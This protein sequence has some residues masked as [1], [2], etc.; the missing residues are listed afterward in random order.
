VTNLSRSLRDDYNP[1]WS[2]DGQYVAFFHRSQQ[3]T[4]QPNQLRIAEVGAGRIRAVS[5]QEGAIYNVRWSPDSQRLWFRMDSAYY[6]YDRA[7][8]AVRELYRISASN[9]YFDSFSESPD[10]RWAL[11]VTTRYEPDTSNTHTNVLLL[12]TASGTTEIVPFS[13]FRLWQVIWSRD[14][15]RVA[16]TNNT[17]YAFVYE[18]ASRRLRHVYVPPPGYTQLWDWS[19]DNRLVWTVARQ[20]GYETHTTFYIGDGHDSPIQELVTIHPPVELVRASPTENLI[21]FQ[22]YAGIYGIDAAR[23]GVF[24]QYVQG[25]GKIGGITWSPDGR[26]LASQIHGIPGRNTHVMAVSD[27]HTGERYLYDE[28]TWVQRD[29]RWSQTGSQLAFTSG[30]R[31]NMELVTLTMPE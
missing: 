21:A 7:S 16:V 22:T 5:R 8:R 29:P 12:D 2:P 20:V 1:I 6:V 30:W 28:D 31:G 15:S 9:T 13:G 25:I 4:S 14:S 26:Y 19:F 17:T 18:I 10:G 23:T 3:Y 27:V 11:V 24:H